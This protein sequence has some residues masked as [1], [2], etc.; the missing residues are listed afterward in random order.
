MKLKYGKTISFK[1][2]SSFATEFGTSIK[3]LNCIVNGHIYCL[4]GVVNFQNDFLQ[5]NASDQNINPWNSKIAALQGEDFEISL[6]D[7]PNRWLNQ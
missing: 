1:I 5:I 6:V 7:I 3:L 4:G 2:Q